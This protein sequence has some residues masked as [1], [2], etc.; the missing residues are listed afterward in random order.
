MGSVDHPHVHTTHLFNRSCQIFMNSK[1]APQ[2]MKF[3]GAIQK[4]ASWYALI[5]TQKWRENPTY[6]AVTEAK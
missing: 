3:L 6:S 1:N 2:K 4:V 5:Q